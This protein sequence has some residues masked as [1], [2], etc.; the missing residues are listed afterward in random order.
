VVQADAVQRTGQPVNGHP[1][2]SLLPEPSARAGDVAHQR[3]SISGQDMPARRAARTRSCSFRARQHLSSR[4]ARSSKPSSSAPIGTRVVVVV[5]SSSRAS[6]RALRR[7]R[8]TRPV[9]A[10]S[11]SRSTVSDSVMART[12]RAANEFGVA[13]QFHQHEYHA[14]WSIRVTVNPTTLG[15][16]L[17]LLGSGACTA[18]IP[19]CTAGQVRASGV[20]T[21]TTSSS[22]GSSTPRCS[23]PAGSPPPPP[24]G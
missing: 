2:R 4:I 3:V 6:S 11:S 24:R 1:H 9:A 7:R 21:T 16:N 17:A 22:L 13:P 8:S 19:A 14:G 18:P 15:G 10:K 23:A 12:I 20:G 5:G